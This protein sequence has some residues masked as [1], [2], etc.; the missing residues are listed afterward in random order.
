MPYRAATDLATAGSSAV[1]AA[2]VGLDLIDIVSHS[3]TVTMA[4]LALILAVGRV[5]LMIREWRS[6]DGTR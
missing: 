4:V 5:A 2:G 3:Y 6:K 1:M